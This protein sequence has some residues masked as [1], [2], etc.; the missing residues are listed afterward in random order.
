M[1]KSW[2]N[3]IEFN[4]GADKIGVDVMR[5][6]FI[7]SN[8]AENLLFGY[9]KTDEVRRQFYL[10]LWNVYKF[11]IEYSQLDKFKNQKSRLRQGYGGQAKSKNILDKWIINRLVWLTRHVEKQLKEYNPKEAAVEIEKFVSDLSIWY[12]RRS[13]DRV[14]T[15]S[16]NLDDKKHFY[17]TLRFILIPL[18]IILSPFMPFISEEIFTSLTSLESVHLSNW[19]D[20]SRQK[21]NDDLIT[22]MNT[23]RTIVE[24]GHSKRKELQIKVRQPL[25][26]IEIMYSKKELFKKKENVEDYYRLLSNELN[27]KYVVI[28]E[29]KNIEMMEVVFDTYLTEDLIIEGKL[30]DLLRQIQQ[31]RKQLGVRQDQYISVVIP[32]EFARFKVQIQKKILSKEIKYGNELKILI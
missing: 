17:E 1:H 24:A 10:I 23:L 3:A 14:W 5:W 31:Q 11:Y 26:K 20:F 2:G 9:K 4:E 16:D 15:N 7:K 13:R 6:L 30:R 25:A 27:V 12:I 18:S 22:D 28:I 29:K 19:P 21:I 8:P 32:K